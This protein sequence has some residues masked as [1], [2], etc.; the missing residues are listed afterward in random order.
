MASNIRLLYLV[1]TSDAC[2]HI[3]LITTW[4]HISV[5]VFSFKFIQYFQKVFFRIFVYD[6]FHKFNWERFHSNYLC[7]YNWK[8]NACKVQIK[9]SFTRSQLKFC[10][11][12]AS[13]QDIRSVQYLYHDLWPKILKNIFEAVGLRHRSF[14][15]SF[16]AQSIHNSYFCCSYFKPKLIFRT[17]TF[18]H[19]MRIVL[20]SKFKKTQK[21]GCM[22]LPIK[23]Y[24]LK[25]NYFS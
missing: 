3:D 10:S 20:L 1:F 13:L 17:Y 23:N 4:S 11:K 19:A 16:F 15:Y 5:L 14:C 18:Q 12:I 22:K 6:G 24:V 8:S 2:G 7:M 25:S 21:C 9:K